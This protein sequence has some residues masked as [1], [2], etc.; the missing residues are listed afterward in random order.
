MHEW[1]GVRSGKSEAPG[2]LYVSPAAHV[3]RMEVLHVDDIHDAGSGA[4][5]RSRRIDLPWTRG[6]A[7]KP[8]YD[9]SDPLWLEIVSVVLFFMACFLLLAVFG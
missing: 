5:D 9:A 1:G 2:G 6:A 3:V 8:P 4:C 7:V